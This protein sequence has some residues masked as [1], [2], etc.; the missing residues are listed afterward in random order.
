MMEPCHIKFKSKYISVSD[1]KMQCP[2]IFISSKPP[3]TFIDKLIIVCNNCKFFIDTF[4][5][6]KDYYYFLI[7]KG[8]LMEAIHLDNGSKNYEEHYKL[9]KKIKTITFLKFLFKIKINY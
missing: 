2:I 6:N 3:S 4:L 9:N 5:F 1:N 8:F 7:L